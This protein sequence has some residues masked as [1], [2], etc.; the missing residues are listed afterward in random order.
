MITFINTSL[1]QHIDDQFNEFITPENRN[2]NTTEIYKI[3][4]KKI[5]DSLF[6]NYNCFIS[7][8]FAASLVRRVSLGF[9]DRAKNVYDYYNNDITKDIDIFFDSYSHAV[10]AANDIL[11]LNLRLNPLYTKSW[12]SDIS[13]HLHSH[14]FNKINI[15]K[16]FNG[17]PEKVLN[18]FDISNAM[19]AY[20]P[21]EITF[22]DDW[23]ELET[24]N[25][26]RMNKYG[27]FSLSRL[28]KWLKNHKYES[29]IDDN[30]FIEKFKS[31]V[32]NNI[33]MYDNDN[34]EQQSKAKHINKLD[35]NSYILDSKD[36]KHIYIVKKMLATALKQFDFDKEFLIKLFFCVQN[37]RQFED[38]YDKY[39]KFLVEKGID[40]NAERSKA[41]KTTIPI[42]TNETFWQ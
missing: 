34:V 21:G 2:K 20:R 23:F 8:G 15:I 41:V 38:D 37:E 12:E 39:A 24:K 27:N 3:N 29:I 26:L 14:Y 10:D 16:I 1:T 7:G 4:V 22:I 9:T 18:T 13:I 31:E 36:L 32:L 17:T 35:L 42:D 28:I 5:F 30:I 33:K 11:R 6:A 25:Q 19:I 40:I